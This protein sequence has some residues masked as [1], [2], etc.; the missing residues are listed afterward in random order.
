VSCGF[1]REALAL[2]VEGDLCADG[3]EATV[4]HLASCAEC[5]RLVEELRASQ[6][7]VK[8]MRGETVDAVECAA[9][10]REVM[11]IISERPETLCWTVRIER[12]IAL[13][14]RPS[15]GLAAFLLFGIVSVSVLAQIGPVAHRR[16]SA[17]VLEG[18]DTL[19]RP[20][21]YRAWT[22]VSGA[23][24]DPAARSLPSADRVY[25]DP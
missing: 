7:L 24:S 9:M 11:A 1:S 21:G 4:N 6:V 3:A 16:V 5:R 17:D 8:S 23:V 22:V 12:A 25:M 18:P 15:H 13:G 10:R 20:A 19:L 2:H 14:L